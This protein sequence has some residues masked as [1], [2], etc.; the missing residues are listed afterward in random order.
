MLENKKIANFYNKNGFFI[1]KNL[2]KKSDIDKISLRLNFLSKNQKNIRRGLSEPGVKTSL[3]Y[4]LHNDSLLKKIIEENNLFK[5]TIK[6]ILKSDD[7][8]IWNAKSNIKKRWH[9]SAEYYHQDFAYWKGYGFKSTNMMSCMIFVD[10]HKHLN[11]GMWIFPGT[12]KKLYKHEKFININSLQKN[13]IPQKTLDKLRKKK[14]PISLDNKAGSCI[15]FHCNLIHGSAHNISPQDRKII[16]YQI[17]TLKEYDEK[18]IKRVNKNNV[19]KRK[20]FEKKQLQIRMSKLNE[21]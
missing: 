16:L 21:V 12:H 20:K 4:N 8:K 9:G 19:L 17:S 13:L 1:I 15:F 3:I 10:D 14:S 5:S 7:Y 11:G 18:L 2:I 6:T